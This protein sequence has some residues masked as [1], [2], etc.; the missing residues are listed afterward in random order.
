MLSFLAASFWLIGEKVANA[1]VERL[2]EANI[3]DYG[4]LAIRI[5]KNY[6]FNGLPRAFN[7]DVD[8]KLLSNLSRLE[9]R[10]FLLN[11]THKLYRE[12][13]NQYLDTILQLS[14]QYKVDPIWVISVVTIES[15]F[16]SKA[17]S[18]KN[19]RGL[20]QVKPDTAQHLRELLRFKVDHNDKGEELYSPNKNLELGIF[21]L[22]RL[23]QNFRY[24]YDLATIAYNQGPN[25]L[26]LRLKEDAIIVEEN[27]YFKKV[28]QVYGGYIKPY[29]KL[30]YGRTF[31]LQKSQN[32]SLKV[33]LEPSF[34]IAKNLKSEIPYI[35]HSERL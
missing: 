16:D 23:L 10:N 9:L 13:L 12:G 35:Y 30:V 18:H 19:A 14:E 24:K 11:S 1:N 21:Y 17:K 22:K 28:N 32:L 29:Q 8:L 20:M 31:E 6:D 34:K 5:S 3:V 4:P 2:I 15:G 33:N 25:S 27:N 7:P 26:R